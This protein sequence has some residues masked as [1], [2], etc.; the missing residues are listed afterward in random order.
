MPNIILIS[1]IFFSGSLG[2]SI[3][4]KRSNPGIY[5]SKVTPGGVAEKH[6]GVDLGRRSLNINGQ[7]VKYMRQPDFIAILKVGVF[8][9]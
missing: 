3:T 4:E 5:I 6:G 2:L 8:K 7:N 9:G 1:K